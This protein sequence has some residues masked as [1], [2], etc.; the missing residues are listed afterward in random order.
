[1][2]VGVQSDDQSDVIGRFSLPTT[3]DRQTSIKRVSSKAF[4]IINNYALMICSGMF[5]D[6]LS[7]EPER[8]SDMFSN[9]QLQYQAVMGIQSARKVSENIYVSSSVD[10]FSVVF[11]AF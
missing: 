5:D 3:I 7:E 1:M 11:Y 8:G 6:Y 10:N 2:E 9:A 4:N